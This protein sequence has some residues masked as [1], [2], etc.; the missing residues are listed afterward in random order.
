MRTLLAVLA[1]AAVAALGGA[2]LGEYTLANLVAVLA[3]LLF[4]V[5][6]GEATGAVQRPPRPLA[7]AAAGVFT[8]SAWVWSLWISTGHHLG[9]TSVAQWVGTP[10]AGGAAVAW[11]ATAARASRPRGPA[12]S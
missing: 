9:Y 10:C 1:A 12:G 8:P 5:V 3:C 11:A 2:I 4:G 7:L 6:V